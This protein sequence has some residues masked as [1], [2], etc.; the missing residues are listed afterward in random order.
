MRIVQQRLDLALEIAPVSAI[1]F[2]RNFER[3][4]Y[5]LGNFDGAIHSLFRRGAP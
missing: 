1:D 5:P 2:R 4:P 3:H